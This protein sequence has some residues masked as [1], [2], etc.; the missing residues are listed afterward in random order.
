MITPSF[1]KSRAPRLF[2]LT[3]ELG[4]LVVTSRGTEGT[5]VGQ[6]VPV[7]H[8]I[9]RAGL[10]PVSDAECDGD[11]EKRSMYEVAMENLD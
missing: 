4:V 11:E 6:N 3:L 10:R 8:P 2:F 5:R 9:S 7:W 1:Q